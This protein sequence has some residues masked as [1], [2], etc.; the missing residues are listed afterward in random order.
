MWTTMVPGGAATLPGPAAVVRAL[1]TAGGDRTDFSA[2]GPDRLRPPPHP[3]R[4]RR[5]MA[6]PRA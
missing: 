2:I 6:N 3:R 5:G 1:S 4:R